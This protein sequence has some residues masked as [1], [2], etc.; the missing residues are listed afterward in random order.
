MY[1][2][3]IAISLLWMY[4]VLYL[5]YMFSM[6][7]QGL[8]ICIFLGVLIPWLIDKKYKK[9]VILTVLCGFLHA[10]AFLF[11]IMPIVGKL[12]MK[13][14]SVIFMGSI[15]VLAVF[16]IPPIRNAVVGF[17]PEA[18]KYYAM[19]AE[20]GIRWFALAERI[21]VFLMMIYLFYEYKKRCFGVE[22]L[23]GKDYTELFMKIYI[24]GIAI[25]MAFAWNALISTRLSMMFKLLEIIIIPN[26]LIKGGYFKHIIFIAFLCLNIMTYFKN[27]DSFLTQLNFYT[28]VTV[29]NYPYVS[30]WN[31]DTLTEARPLQRGY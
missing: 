6:M 30:I 22:F 9:Y 13:Q 2:K 20:I 21:V 17:M 31:K 25:Y 27:V 12:K 15:A 1:S 8:V 4:P 19:D 16:V 18:V 7:R 29:F 5:L 24:V 14:I 28:H 3:N 23:L 10:S 11:L 26:M